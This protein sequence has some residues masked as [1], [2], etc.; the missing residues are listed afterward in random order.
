MWRGSPRARRSAATGGGSCLCTACRVLGEEV[1]LERRV[2]ENV[3]T[4]EPA[5]QLDRVIGPVALVDQHQSDQESRS[6]QAE[7]AMDEDALAGG[8]QLVQKGRGKV[9]LG[10]V[11]N[12]VR[13]RVRRMQIEDAGGNV[14]EPERIDVRD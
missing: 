11:R 1:T 7:A 9:E 4:S 14:V 2:L 8:S 13:I 3:R 6:V 5:H 12:R 10:R